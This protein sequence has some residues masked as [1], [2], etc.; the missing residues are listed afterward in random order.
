MIQNKF[1]EDG[2]GEKILLQGEELW[3]NN[4]LLL[5]ICFSLIN[6]LDDEFSENNKFGD[7]VA[8]MAEKI[9][10]TIRQENQPNDDAGNA[11]LITP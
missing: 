4:V 5:S 11:G 7:K 2:I 6:I 1:G 3:V 10:E 9:Y 8:S